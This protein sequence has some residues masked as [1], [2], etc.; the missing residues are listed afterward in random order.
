MKV[1]A[2]SGIR[3][4]KQDKE[5]G[6]WFGKLL[7][8]LSQMDICQPQQAIKSGRNKLI[9]KKLILKKA[10]M[11]M[12][13][14]TLKTLAS[15]TC[16]KEILDFLNQKSQQQAARDYAFLKIMAALA[17]QPNP[18]ITSPVIRHMSEPRNQF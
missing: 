10:I 5:I 8:S 12:F 16:S 18:A 9:A 15:H 2:S 7:P 3:H 13:V 6:S 11:M 14:S 17:Q 1:K 4:F